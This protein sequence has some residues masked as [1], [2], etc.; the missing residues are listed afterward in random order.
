MAEDVKILES[1]V[2]ALNKAFDV[3]DKV[4]DGEFVQLEAGT[5]KIA[6]QAIARIAEKEPDLAKDVKHFFTLIEEKKFQKLEAE[7]MRRGINEV[8]QIIDR[9]KGKFSA[10]FAAKLSGRSPIQR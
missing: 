2:E 6:L 8:S 10:K 5:I 1:E 4:V 9:V 7:I 3:I